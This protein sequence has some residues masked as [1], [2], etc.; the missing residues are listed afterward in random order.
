MKI[1]FGVLNIYEL[2]SKKT[3]HI[4]NFGTFWYAPEAGSMKNVVEVRKSKRRSVR[5]HR[6]KPEAKRLAQVGEIAR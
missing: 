2:L 4:G 5:Q 6:K 3:D 1:S